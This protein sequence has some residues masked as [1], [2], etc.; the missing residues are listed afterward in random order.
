[1]E[2][3][4]IIKKQKD[5]NTDHQVLVAHNLLLKIKSPS[6]WTDEV[7]LTLHHYKIINNKNLY[8]GNFRSFECSL[9]L[10]NQQT[11]NFY[12][13]HVLKIALAKFR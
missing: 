7:I 3:N 1:M 4:A 5:E 9:Y 10:H 12:K 13:I 2:R 11:G 8:F 6:R